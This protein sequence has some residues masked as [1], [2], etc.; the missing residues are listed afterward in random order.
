M[1]LVR[2]G[3]GGLERLSRSS[4]DA[5]RHAACRSRSTSPSAACW[6][7]SFA[8][9]PSSLA[10]LASKGVSASVGERTAMISQYS[11]GTNASRSRSRST[12]SRSATLCTRPALRPRTIFLLIS[13]LSS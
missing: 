8:A 3:A 5:T 6:S 10:S 12:I 13:G 4:M 7:P 11:S 2:K 9:S 1:V